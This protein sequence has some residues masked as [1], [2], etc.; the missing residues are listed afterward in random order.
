MLTTTGVPSL[1][2]DVVTRTKVPVVAV[3]VVI[4]GLLLLTTVTFGNTEY[5]VKTSVK[6]AN[7]IV[8]RIGEVG[9]AGIKKTIESVLSVTP[10][11]GMARVSLT[12]PF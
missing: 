11:G 8:S 6:L 4:G 2:D 5:I 12:V 10:G 7:V 3:P 1:P 9:T